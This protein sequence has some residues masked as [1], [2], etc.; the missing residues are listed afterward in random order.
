MVVQAYSFGSLPAQKKP[1]RLQTDVLQ[2]F[3]L[4]LSALY[5]MGK[6][7]IRNKGKT[8]SLPHPTP[9]FHIKLPYAP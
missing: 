9:A 2:A 8:C 1:V 6:T 7:G 3:R 4:V 5:S